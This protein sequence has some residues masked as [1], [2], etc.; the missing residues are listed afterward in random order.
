[1][2]DPRRWMALL[3]AGW[4]GL[5]LTVAA[6]AT[7]APFA[8]LA[9]PD[10]GRVVAIV[11]SREAAASVL[12]G[13][14]ILLLQRWRVRRDL[15]QGRPVRQADRSWLLAAGAVFCTVAGYYG[16][17]PWMAQAR[18]G[19]GLLSFGQLHAISAAF[20]GIKLL[21]VAALAW[22]TGRPAGS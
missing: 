4:L 8:A 16:V 9:K 10:A 13:A 22:L 5:L 1:M 17:Q 20:F 7:P 14:A 2:R 6:I 15:E 12:L 3:A 21:L 18:E 11:L 19:Q